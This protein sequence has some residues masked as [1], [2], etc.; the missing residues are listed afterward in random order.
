MKVFPYIACAALA[1]LALTEAQQQIIPK[2]V[3]IK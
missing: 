3:S 2:P 1:S